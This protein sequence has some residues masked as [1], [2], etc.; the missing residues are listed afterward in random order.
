MSESIVDRQEKIRAKFASFTDPDD[1]WKFL[2][3]LAREHKGMDASLKAEKFIIQGCAS[4]MYLV[5]KFD[6]AKIHFEMDVEGGTTN[7]LISRGLGAL[8]LQIFNDMAPADILS[9][10]PTFFQQIGLNVGLSP[11]R[12]N[13]FASLLK[14]IYLYAR[15]FDAISKK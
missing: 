3:D 12:S 2:L 1:K 9:V 4:T 7:P 6:G 10:D 5:P 13:G 11:T 15:V 14:Q 8:A